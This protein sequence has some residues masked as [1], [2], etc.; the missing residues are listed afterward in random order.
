MNSLYENNIFKNTPDHSIVTIY[1][2]NNKIFQ[3]IY[4][5]GKHSIY[6]LMHFIINELNYNCNNKRLIEDYEFINNGKS[7]NLT[8]DPVKTHNILQNSQMLHLKLKHDTLSNQM[9]PFPDIT[10]DSEKFIIGTDT[11]NVFIKTISGRSITIMVN[12]KITTVYELM[13]HI[14]NVEGIP[15][16]QQRIIY[17]CC[18]LKP[19]NLLSDYYINDQARLHLVLRLRGGM[20]NEVSGKNGNYDELNNIIIDITSYDY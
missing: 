2:I 7:I 16:E 14:E 18:Q 17:E 11:I 6:S 12:P 19:E 8:K 5:I 1:T 4:E 10:Y 20:Y 9:I 3:L 15:P 13:L